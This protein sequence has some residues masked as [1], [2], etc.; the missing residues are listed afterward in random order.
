MGSAIGITLAL[1]IVV[2]VIAVVLLVVRSGPKD[3]D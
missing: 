1:G 3:R 2:T